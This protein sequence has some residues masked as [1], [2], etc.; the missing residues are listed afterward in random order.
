[1][2]PPTGTGRRVLPAPWGGPYASGMTSARDARLLDA[3][4]K[5]IAVF[6]ARNSTDL[7]VTELCAAIGLAERTFYR[8]FPT[9][10]QTILPVFE[11]MT[12]RFAASIESG[13]P[14]LVT[15]LH[16]AFVA[17]VIG[18]EAGDVVTFFRLIRADHDL[19]SSFLEVI[20]RA[21]LDLAAPIGRRLGHRPGDIHSRAAAI[22]VVS[23]SRLALE[24]AA[25]DGADPI[26]VFD[27]YVA[28]FGHPVVPTD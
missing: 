16:D 6:V 8:Y 23:A 25:V 11:E 12:R 9:K 5:C 20:Q 27:A 7:T 26:E 14:Q 17:N 13:P 19:W 10:A 24:A 28:A 15:A 18:L 4:E 21:E 22:A 2:P 1:L 3:S